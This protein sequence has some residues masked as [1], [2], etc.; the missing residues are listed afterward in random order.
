MTN[1]LDI[2][3]QDLAFLRGL[4]D[5]SRPML[6]P[7]GAALAIAGVV[8]GLSALRFWAVGQGWIGWPPALR[9]LMGLDGLIVQIVVMVA[10]VWI[11]PAAMRMPKRTSGPAGRAARGAVNA[12]GWALGAAFVGLFVASKRLG[13]GE[14]MDTGLPIV[15]FALASAAWWVLFAVYRRAWALVAAVASALFA[16]G[17]GLAAGTSGG[18][19]IVAAG[20][21]ACVAAPGLALIRQSREP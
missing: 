14:P 6:R 1:D 19:L 10:A 21:F 9:P 7:L 8:H 18:A 20:L 3:R 12:L 11:W 15:L 13:G 17:L 2:A 16:A 5:D 4:A